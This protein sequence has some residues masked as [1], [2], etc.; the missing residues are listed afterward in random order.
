M[1]LFVV[2]MCDVIVLS[3]VN[4]L[5][6]LCLMN[7]VIRVASVATSSSANAFIVCV[8]VLGLSNNKFGVCVV[9]NLIFIVVNRNFICINCWMIFFVGYFNSSGAR[10]NNIGEFTNGVIRFR[11]N[12]V[13]FNCFGFLYVLFW[14]FFVII[15]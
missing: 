9:M 7:S 1:V 8:N 4:V 6:L 11:F 13:C 12:I 10:C 3:V 5:I 15:V 2:F 14:V